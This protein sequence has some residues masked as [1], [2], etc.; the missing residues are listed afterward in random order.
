MGHLFLFYIASAFLVFWGI[1]HLVPTKSVIRGFGDISRDNKRIIMMEWI[2]EGVTLI[3]TG[4]L[5]SVL[6][7]LNS[8]YEI[9]GFVLSL[10]VAFIIILAL[11][12]FFTG[13]RVKFLPF[14][15]CPFVLITSALLILVGLF[16]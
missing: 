14:R 2:I 5:I 4:L 9:S 10:I 7:L 15:L 12:S 3:F 6:T 8:Y 16:L 13:F 11:V 1:A